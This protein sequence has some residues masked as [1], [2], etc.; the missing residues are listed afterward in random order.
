MRTG[1]WKQVYSGRAIYPLDPRRDEIFSEDISHALAHTCRFGGHCREF[2]SVAEHSVRVA[3]VVE[4]MAAAQKLD[5]DSARKLKRAALLHDAAEAF[6]VDMP[7]PIKHDPLLARYVEI[8]EKWQA[9]VNDRFG[10]EPDAH[11]HHAI[12]QADNILLATER[13]DLMLPS[14]KAWMLTEEPLTLRLVPWDPGKAKRAFAAL[15]EELFP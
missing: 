15:L 1:D 2:Y 12:K 3:N 7:R 9:C 8:E 14:E 5:G 4:T 11:R 6:L 10:L 13:R